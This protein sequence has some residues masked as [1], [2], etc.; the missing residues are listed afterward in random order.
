MH[1]WL[2]IF[3]SLAVKSSTAAFCLDDR[4]NVYDS[5]TVALASYE[6]LTNEQK[7]T[8]KLWEGI[9]WDITPSYELIPLIK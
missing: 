3:C 2:L 7:K 6:L 8:A 1:T 4:W 9:R 5:S